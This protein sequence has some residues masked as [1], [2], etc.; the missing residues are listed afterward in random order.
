MLDQVD[1]TFNGRTIAYL[2]GIHDH[3]AV[4]VCKRGRRANE[5]KSANADSTLSEVFLVVLSKNAY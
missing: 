2:R 5:N 1:V 3:K 4:V